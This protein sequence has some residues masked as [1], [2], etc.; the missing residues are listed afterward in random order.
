MGT[1]LLYRRPVA[2]VIGEKLANSL[3]APGRGLAAVGPDWALPM[4]VTA[5]ARERG[6]LL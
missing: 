3:L 6:G 2:Q 5:G 4:G 1:S